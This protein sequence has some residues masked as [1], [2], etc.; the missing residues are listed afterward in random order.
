MQSLGESLEAR[1]VRF[2]PVS[3]PAVLS[4][5]HD[6]SAEGDVDSPFFFI[7]MLGKIIFFCSGFRQVLTPFFFF[8]VLFLDLRGLP[9]SM[10]KKAIRVRHRKECLSA[11]EE[12]FGDGPGVEGDFI[13]I[14][15]FALVTLVVRL[16]IGLHFFSHY[17]RASSFHFADK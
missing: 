15:F 5:N 14:N 2:I 12:I 17:W 6:S 8:W 16:E 3:T 1:G 11:V 10:Q 4:R 13:L 7:V 9:F